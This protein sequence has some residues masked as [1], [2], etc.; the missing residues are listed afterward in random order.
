[1]GRGAAWALVAAVFA[2][3]P[4]SVVH[5]GADLC[6]G[7]APVFSGDPCSPTTGPFP[8]LPGLPLVLPVDGPTGAWTAGTPTVSHAFTGDVDLAV[9]VGTFPAP[10]Q[11]PAPAGSPGNP[12]LL[13]NVAGGGGSGQGSEI[14]FTVMVTDGPG[15]FPYGSVLSGPEMDERPVAVFAFPDLDGDGVIGPTDT[16]GTADNAIEKQEAIAHLGREL[17][18]ISAGTFTNSLG[19]QL[20]APASLGGLVVGLA[21]GMYT[22]SNADALW[23]DGTPLFTQWPFFPPLDPIQIVYLNEPNPPDSE[24]PNILFYRPSQFLLTP[25][26]DADLPEAFAVASDGSNPSTD[27]F[28]SIS[29]PAVGLRLFRNV[30]PGNFAPSSRMVAKIAPTTNGLSRTLVLP[31]GEISISPGQLVELRLLPVDLLGNIADPTMPGLA[32]K[33]VAEGG[34]KILSPDLDGNSGE[35]LVTISSAIGKV[36][37]LGTSGINGSA[38]LSIVDAPPQFPVLRDQA[39]VLGKQGTVVALDSDD[40]GIPDDGDGSM[41]IGDHPC[42]PADI[43]N[44]S[45]CDDNC[46]GM[47][48]PAQADSDGDGQGNCCD[49]TCVVD[50]SSAGCLQCPSAGARFHSLFTRVRSRIQPRAGISEDRVKISATLVLGDGQSIAPDS[51]SVE[52]ALVENERLHYFAQLAGAFVQTDARPTYTYQ[53]P[54]GSVAGVR[55]VR[56]RATPSGVYRLTLIARKVGLVDTQP[57]ETLADGLVLSVNIGDDAFSNQLACVSSLRSVRCASGR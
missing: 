12:T 56:L 55:R 20:A 7:L 2:A 4:S 19:V 48:N 40:D 5:A 25:P 31:A 22:G 30:D 36:I 32:I 38:R 26:S 13:Q 21:A 17:G 18:Q 1:M 45:P 29:G 11:V 49:G 28:V 9:R 6:V 53:D 15:T 3:A 47:V 51:E 43:A 16:D 41:V 24:G 50:D 42:T 10:T 35:E 27:Q 37:A 14:N 54:S 33:L 34:M 57:A 8:M 44:S 23:S 39:L 46:P 52:I